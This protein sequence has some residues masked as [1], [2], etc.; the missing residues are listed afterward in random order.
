M[1]ES[2]ITRNM[3]TDCQNTMQ[4]PTCD[5]HHPGCNCDECCKTSQSICEDH[6]CAEGQQSSE[7]KK[8]MR[9]KLVPIL[10]NCVVLLAIVGV[11]GRIIE[12]RQI[13]HTPEN[14][15]AAIAKLAGIQGREINNGVIA[16]YNIHA[17]DNAIV[18]ADPINLIN[19]R[20]FDRANI[21]VRN[22]RARII[23]SIEI[24][25]ITPTAIAIAH[26]IDD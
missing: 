9:N 21:A 17:I 13:N 16:G 22:N 1:T 3:S 20:D 11:S 19:I 24:P 8:K 12:A 6:D 7:G 15:A 18:A 5:V 25:T 14:N 26:R 10:A 4:K 23:S 2:D